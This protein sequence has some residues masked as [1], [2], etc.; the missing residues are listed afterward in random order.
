[1]RMKRHDWLVAACAGAVFLAALPARASD[2]VVTNF[3]T[4]IF[5]VPYSVGLEKGIFKAAGAPVTGVVNGGGGG[6]VLRTLLANELPFGEVATTAVIAAQHEGLDVVIV[7]GALHTFDDT[8]FVLPNAPIHSVKDWVGK[9]IAYTTPQSSSQANVL[10]VLNHFGIAPDAVTMVATGGYAQSLTMLDAG[11]V[12]VAMAGAPLSYFKRHKYREI[13]KSDD[14][15]PP[16]LAGLCVTTRVYLNQHPDTIRAILLARQRAIE[17][18]N[19]H[20]KE[21]GAIAARDYELDPVVF[22][23]AVEDATKA[24]APIWVPGDI[25][26][27]ELVRLQNDMRLTGMNVDADWSKLIDLSYLPPDLQAKSRL[28]PH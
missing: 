22:G 7:G 10:I 25:D 6:G 4:N 8:Y 27:D 14:V 1:M 5:G 20:P 26:I 16:T 23:H 11:A 28:T 12:D 15:E 18:V 2:V 9:R 17:Y 13:I 3:G 24:R 19:S 21:A